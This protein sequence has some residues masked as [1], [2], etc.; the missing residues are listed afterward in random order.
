MERPERAEVGEMRPLNP[1]DLETGRERSE[2]TE[3][4]EMERLN[5]PDLE[6][7]REERGEGPA[8]AESGE[9]GGG[10]GDRVRCWI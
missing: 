8:R 10:A 4:F 1:P 6:T 9:G 5:P 3:A 7:D 2:G